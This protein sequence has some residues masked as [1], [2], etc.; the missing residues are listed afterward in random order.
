VE[1]SPAIPFFHYLETPQFSKT[2]QRPYESLNIMHS[3]SLCSAH[4]CSENG[5]KWFLFAF[6]DLGA[7]LG[8]ALFLN[9]LPQPAFSNPQK[10]AERN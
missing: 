10:F 2:L 8:F 1:T 7:D 5:L 4:A 6:C 3:A 9:S